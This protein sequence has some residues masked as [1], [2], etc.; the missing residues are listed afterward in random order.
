[1]LQFRLRTVVF[2]CWWEIVPEEDCDKYFSLE[3]P[4]GALEHILGPCL[5]KVPGP[6]LAK[7]ESVDLSDHRR[8]SVHLR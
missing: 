4:S 8:A 3:E 6:N 1:V 7:L 5:E 2:P